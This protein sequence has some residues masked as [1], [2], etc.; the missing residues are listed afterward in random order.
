M[1]EITEQELQ[2]LQRFRLTELARGA[3]YKESVF[4]RLMGGLPSDQYT[5]VS[6]PE[7]G[8]P[9]MKVGEE[10]PVP[11]K[12]FVEK[13]WKDFLPSLKVEEV[14]TPTVIPF[15]RQAAEGQDAGNKSAT[16]KIVDNYIEKQYGA[17]L[18]T[19]TVN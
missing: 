8:K 7:T 11:L 2:E 17:V 5:L 1:P 13:E 18:K 6:D 19:E 3:G 10:E 16:R 14:K 4:I 12:D 15:V 9:S